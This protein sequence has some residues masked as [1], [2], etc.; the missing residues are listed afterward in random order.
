MHASGTLKKRTNTVEHARNRKQASSWKAWWP[1]LLLAAVTVGVFGNSLAN[2]FV[3]DDGFQI[4]ENSAITDWRQIPAIFGQDIWSFVGKP[5]P[6]LRHLPSNYYRPIQG[7][8]YMAVY[9]AAGLKPW[10]FHAAMLLLH[11]ANVLLVYAVA[12]KWFRWEA[13]L[14]AALVFA[15]HPIHNEPV[16]WIAAMPDLIVTTLILA[17]VVLF[18]KWDGAPGA[19]QS[20]RL[21][22][23]FLAAL[24]TKESAAMLPILLAGYE[25]LILGR[26]LF[27]RSEA[28][29][30]A[31]T[32][33][34][35]HK[36]YCG[37]A[38]M[39]LIYF[40]FRIFALRALAPAQGRYWDVHGFPL[41][42]STIA[43]FG[44]GLWSL[45]WPA[46]LSYFHV[47]DP[48]QSITPAVALSALAIAAAATTI[49]MA[50]RRWPAVSYG[51]LWLLVCLAPTL[52]INGV[53][54]NVFAERYMY[55][56]S[57]GLVFALAA[58]LEW[59]IIRQPVLAWSAVGVLCAVSA[60]ILIPRNRDWSDNIRLFS[61]TVRDE[62]RAGSTF[63]ALCSI[64]A[65]QRRF[66]E[67]AKSCEGA[68]RIYPNESEYHEILGLAHMK[69][70][71]LGD[72]LR[73]LRKAVELEPEP[74]QYHFNLAS[75]LELG[76][77]SDEATHEYDTALGIKPNFPEAL[78]A[79]A[80]QSIDRKD[81]PE[82]IQLLQRAISINPGYIDAYIYLGVAYRELGQDRDSVHAFQSAIENGATHPKIYLAHYYLGLAYLHL[83]SPQDAIQELGKA[84]NL[85]PDFT[86]AQR[87]LEQLRQALAGG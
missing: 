51:L 17:A 9:Y 46:H 71:R 44:Q 54:E 58:G 3:S 39:F 10:A 80:A 32:L 12:R 7:I 29:P 52:N 65:E 13:A 36:V 5:A 50:R 27:R 11:L 72:S 8:A 41:V 87:A 14:A 70:N 34:D 60:T 4:L 15:V 6:Y 53:G 85:Q 18:A 78:G 86:P 37:M 45:A 43:I 19:S 16:V 20:V 47:F 48:V 42:L 23:L 30:K 81:Y 66:E 77:A 24:F 84:A 25:V 79:K 22:A 26:P 49:F 62:P 68:L 67:A 56:P 40:A 83:N 61:V 38:A 35:N 82:A 76:G 64:Y 21:S 55:L 74:A 28:A 69:E 2:G 33:W 59:L 75:A 73:E 31:R 57:A 63:G 1:Y